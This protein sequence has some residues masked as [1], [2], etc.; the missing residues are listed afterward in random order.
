MNAWNKLIGRV[1]DTGQFIGG[2]LLMLLIFNAQPVAAEEANVQLSPAD[3]VQVSVFGHADLSGEFEI[4]AMGRL[5]LPL[6]GG[7]SADG[8]TI[9][10]LETAI[11]D[12]LQPEYLLNP[13]VTV[14]LISLRPFYILGEVN[15]PGSYTYT[16]DM[17]VVRAVAVAG[18]FTRRARTKR[19]VIRRVVDGVETEIPADNDTVVQPGDVINIPER[20]F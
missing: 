4:D 3:R 12:A 16:G 19:I 17:T 15:A 13:R 20:F 5:S 8:L 7:L 14:Q 18:G 11:V 9:E 6:I 2:T 1:A 10:E